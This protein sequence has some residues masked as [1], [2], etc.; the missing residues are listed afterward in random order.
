MEDWPYQTNT[1]RI[2]P[3][4]GADCKARILLHKAM[5]EGRW[6]GL[7][8]CQILYWNIFVNHV[9]GNLHI[10]LR[11]DTEL[12]REASFLT[13]SLEDPA[14]PELATF[15]VASEAIN[16]FPN[17]C[18]QSNKELGYQRDFSV[19]DQLVS[20]IMLHAP[21]LGPQL[22]ENVQVPSKVLQ[23]LILH[24]LLWAKVFP[25]GLTNS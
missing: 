20:V 2:C 17:F 12:G 9:W 11:T 1:N 19:K 10:Q 7:V 14:I 18:K 4:G 5:P 3:Q 24:H 6:L 25:S 8:Q 23:S 22:F 13:G 21:E 16:C 15:S